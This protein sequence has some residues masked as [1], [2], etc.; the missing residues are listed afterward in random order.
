MACMGNRSGACKVLVEEP[1]R[2]REIRRPRH[3]WEDNMKR[4][5]K[6][7]GWGQHGLGWSC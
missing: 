6:E 5:L 3:R 2:K 4:D 7:V 1:E